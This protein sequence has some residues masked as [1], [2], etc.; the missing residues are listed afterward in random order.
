LL[1]GV[2]DSRRS[3]DPVLPHLPPSIRAIALSQRGHGD[4]DKPSDAGYTIEDMAGDAAAVIEALELSPAIVVGHSMGGWVAQRLAIDHPERVLATLLVAAPGA[5][6]E[7]AEFVAFLE[8]IS[9]LPGPVD[10][11]L[12]REFQLSTIE[13]PL[14]DEMLEVFVAE[15]MK[16]PTP[17]WREVFGGFLDIDLYDALA[18]LEPPALLVWGDHDAVVTRAAQ[19]RLVETIPQ[20][21]LVVYEGTGHA[22]HWEEPQRFAAQLAAFALGQ[23]RSRTMSSSESSGLSKRAL[24]A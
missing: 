13:R 24:T 18:S 2:T 17:L 8:E 14:P 1:H 23:G 11:E 6:R 16:L 21:R 5:P 4:S 12:A 19:D 9:G 15:S 20:A 10:R 3:W 7:D 22:I